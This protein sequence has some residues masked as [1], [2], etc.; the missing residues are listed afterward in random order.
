MDK[1]VSITSQGQMTIPKSIRKALGIKHATK[2]VLR[3]DGDLLVV[4]PKVDFWSLEGS[5]KSKIKL[6]SKELK[7]ARQAFSKQWPE[8]K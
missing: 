1:I 2:A 4:K 8:T 5:L 7:Q 3:K 6:T